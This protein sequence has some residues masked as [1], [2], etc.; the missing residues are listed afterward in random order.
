ME[1]KEDQYNGILLV[2]HNIEEAATLADRIVIFGNDP[3]T[4]VL[5]YQLLY[6][7]LAI[8]NR[9]SFVLWLIKSIL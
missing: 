6:P 8:L 4:F 5:N 1:R 9:L 2:T 7:N 3:G